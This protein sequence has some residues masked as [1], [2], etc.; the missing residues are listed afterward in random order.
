MRPQKFKQDDIII[1]YGD[2]GTTYYLLSKGTVKVI[3]YEKGTD[4]KDPE[5]ESKVVFTKEMEQGCGFGE[6]AL[7]YNDKRSATIQALTECECYVLDSLAFKGLI[8]K[9][10]MVKREQRLA[11]LNSIK[12]F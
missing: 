1:R 6:L 3:V 9:S 11:F 10:S 2:E 5:L 7:L 12:L 8:V 4:P